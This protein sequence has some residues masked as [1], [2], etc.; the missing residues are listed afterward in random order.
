LLEKIVDL[1]EGESHVAS[2]AFLALFGLVAAHTMLETARDAMFLQKLEATRL[3]FAYAVIAVLAV[4]AAMWSVRSIRTF[5]RLS[6]LV[7]TLMIAAYGTLIFYFQPATSTRVFVLYVWTGLL[8]SVVI[9]QFWMFA[10][11][12]LTI[13]QG[14]RLFGLIGAGGVLGAVAGA[15]AAAGMLVFL[16]VASLLLASTGIFVATALLVTFLKA[17]EGRTPSV[18]QPTRPGVWGDGLVAFR[19]Y[20][21]LWRVAVVVAASTAAVLSTD[22]LFKSVTAAR[23]AGD[24]LGAFFARFYALLN[25]VAL[26]VQVLLTERLLRRFGVAVSLLFLPFLL[27][28]GGA[29]TVVLGAPL[30]VILFT[31]GADGSLRHS[32]H[33]VAFELAYTPLPAEVRDRAKTLLDT[34][35]TR[36]VQALT[37]GLILLLAALGLASPLVLGGLVAVL[38][39]A[40]LLGAIG[41]RRPYLDLFRQALRRG[42]QGRPRLQQLDLDSLAALMEALSSRDSGTV[43][44]ALDLLDEKGRDRF[45]PGLI[46]YHE[47]E[48]VLLRALEI[49]SETER[50]DWVPL[51]Q[52]LLSHDSERV[53]LAVVRSLRHHPKS[54]QAAVLDASPSVRAQAAFSIAHDS[55][56]DPRQD[57]TIRALLSTTG[58]EGTAV[59][60]AFLRALQDQPDARWADL[61]LDMCGAGNPLLTQYAA[62]AVGKLKDPRFIPIL[63]DRLSQRDGRG[64]V[65]E[66]LV[67]FGDPA[68]DAL[69]ARLDDRSAARKARVHIPRTISRF[70]SQR[71][72][73][74][75][76]ERL[77]TEKDGLV[78]Y[79]VLRGLGRLAARATVKIDRERIEAELRRNLIEHLRVLSL[80]V[81][82]ERAQRD[83]DGHATASGRLVLGLLQDKLRQSL[84]RAFRLLQIAHQREDIQSVY[85]AARSED[86]RARAEALEFLDALILTRPGEQM[87]RNRELLRL[88]VDELSAPERV[89]RA[90]SFI[91]APPRDHDEAIASL[92]RDGDESLAAL[93]AYHALE[94]GGE[95]LRQEVA[96]ALEE[97]PALRRWGAQPVGRGAQ[98]TGAPDAS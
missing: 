16:P 13:A 91:P 79:K 33:R 60:I 97:R 53:R 49:L 2:R 76:V 75:L 46:L 12:L 3:T 15:G 17:D 24:E 64:A 55:G 63:I 78:R 95:K 84:E 68:L 19:E 94:T 48:D 86:K 50:M 28:I 22:Y 96:A 59:R 65:R 23:I 67:S 88:V 8:G 36:V 9:V 81:P 82:L 44:A 29:G 30:L 18:A 20:P 10:G 69:E 74:L 31:R 34:S 98:P 4:P 87:E 90:A 41:L 54:L 32:L 73:D 92:L 11:Q 21:Y 40:W 80:T 37:A 7:F 83:A 62:A 71:A 77:R 38:A 56:S 1:R 47:S 57:P 27:L 42:A 52:R 35:L 26:V 43:I 51:A 66:A 25:V 72:A 39:A 93:A 61:V 45:I 14:K 58:E 70:R 5:G 89:A 85:Y 6:T